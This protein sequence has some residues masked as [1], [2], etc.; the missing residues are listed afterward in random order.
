MSDENRAQREALYESVQQIVGGG[1]MGVLVAVVIV[2]EWQ[3]PD[4]QRW[5]TRHDVG[6][7]GLRLPPWQREG[8][9]HNALFGGGWD[10]LPQS[11]V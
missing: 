10:G 2:A 3:T 9:L 11:D 6:A 4:G 1:E 7:D 5:L 8:F